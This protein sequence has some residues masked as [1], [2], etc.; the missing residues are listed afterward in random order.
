MDRFLRIGMKINEEKSIYNKEEVKFLGYQVSYNKIKPSSERSQGIVE[1][2]AP[3]SK[4]ALRKFIGLINYDRIFIKNLS[5]FE[6]LIRE[7]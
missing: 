6:T 5:T 1:F 2:P 4:R 7:D 3:T